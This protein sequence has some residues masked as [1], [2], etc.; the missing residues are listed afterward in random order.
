MLKDCFCSEPMSKVTDYSIPSDNN[1]GEDV[2]VCKNGHRE[3]F[4]EPEYKRRY[5]DEDHVESFWR[6]EQAHHEREQHMNSI[7][8]A[9][10]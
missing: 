1:C 8:Y 4:K 3:E 5:F 10:C 6:S 2:W 9:E 7:H